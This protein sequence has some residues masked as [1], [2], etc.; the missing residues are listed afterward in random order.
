VRLRV[1]L[2][3]VLVAAAVGAAVAVPAVR[4]GLVDALHLHD[5]PADASPVLADGRLPGHTNLRITA[6]AAPP[7]PA[8]A[9]AP[10]NVPTNWFMSWALLDRHTGNMVGSPNYTTGTNTTESMIKAWISSDYLRSLGDKQPSQQRLAELTRMIRD[11]DDD[12]AQDIYRINGGN[13]VIK[14]AIT[15]CGLT[16]STIRS[17]WWS[18]T[19]VTA[20]DAVRLGN[21]VADG[22]AAGPKWTGWV[23]NE[24]RQVRGDVSEEPNGGHW[25]I[26]DG[27]PPDLAKDVSIKNGWTMLY[28]DGQWHVNCLAIHDDWVLAVLTRYPSQ[29]GKAYGAGLCKQV[30]QQ[31]VTTAPAPAGK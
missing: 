16:D 17:G 10:V 24:M 2:S 11:S 21:C 22:R 9:P 3:S 26:V 14:R 4:D 31:L 18:G 27:L 28:A 7:L 12:A 1:V 15:T 25:G 5:D 30:T 29:Q 19:K 6:Q 8:L 20:R 13:A 23:L